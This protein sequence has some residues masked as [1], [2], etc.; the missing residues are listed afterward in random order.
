MERTKILIVDDERSILSL[1]KDALTQWGYQ[2]V[3]AGS[4]AEALTALRA[5]LFAAA[6][7]DIQMPEMSGRELLSEI[8]KHDGSIDVL[9]MTGYPDTTAAVEAISEGGASDYL[10]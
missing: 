4:P 9:L 3:C 10:P 8:K 6:L 5:D 7:V 2:V 1:L